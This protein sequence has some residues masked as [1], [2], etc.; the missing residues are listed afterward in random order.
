MLKSNPIC[1]VCK[2]WLNDDNWQPSCRKGN[3]RICRDCERERHQQWRAANREKEKVTS[4]R[5]HRKQGIRPY[6]ENKECSQFLGVHIAERVLRHVFKD[7]EVMPPGNPSFDFICNQGKRIDVKSSC[8]RKDGSWWF[9]I[10]HNIIADYFLCLAFNDRGRLT[11]LHAWLLPGSKFNH[12]AG[13]SISPNTIR[14]LSKYALDISKINDCCVALR[15]K[16]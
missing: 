10:R 8:L 7:V 1:R 12:L 13:L 11:P 16:E 14:K 5:A 4:T 2:V 15:N 3:R 9:N 6:N